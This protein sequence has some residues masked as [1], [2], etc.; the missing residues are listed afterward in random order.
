MGFPV[1]GQPFGSRF[2]RGFSQSGNILV[3]M[4]NRILTTQPTNLIGY[5][6]LQETSGTAA[7]DVSVTNANG[8]YSGSFSL[9]QPGIGDGSRSVFLTDAAGR[10]S[11][12]TPLA[13]LDAVMNKTLGTLFCWGKIINVAE[14]STGN[15]RRLVNLGADAS[16]RILLA[17][18]TT[19][20]LLTADYRAGGV[21]L[22]RTITSGSLDWFSIGLTWNKAADQAIA[23][24][25]GAQAGA[26]LT[27]LGV[28]AGALA[29]SFSAIGDISSAGTGNCWSDSEAHVALWKTALTAAEMARIGVLLAA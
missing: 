17:R 1:F 22:S 18:S 15:A 26:I 9:N 13:S 8:T 20:N 16:N 4:S 12:A 27:G 19:N 7:D 5:W 2:G 10:V 29:S 24:Y 23:Y 3:S 21:V 28:W 25:N 14:W 6:P 11:L